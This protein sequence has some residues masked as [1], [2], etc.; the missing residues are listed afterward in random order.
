MRFVDFA[1]WVVV[2]KW[3]PRLHQR[4]LDLIR[5]KVAADNPTLAEELLETDA[6]SQR[7]ATVLFVPETGA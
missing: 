4:H 2:V 1:K 6:D 5:G 3:M 7:K